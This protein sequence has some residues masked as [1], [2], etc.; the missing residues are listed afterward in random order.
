M[1]YLLYIF[2][3]EDEKPDQTFFSNSKAL[4]DKQQTLFNKLW[5]T[6]VPLSSRKKE[7]EIEKRD[8]VIKKN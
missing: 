8:N 4:V 7:I 1:A 5:N 6:F 2:H 3:K